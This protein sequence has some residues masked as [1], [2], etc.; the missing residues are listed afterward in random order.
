MS[1]LGTGI[2]QKGIAFMT[3]DRKYHVITSNPGCDVCREGH[4]WT[5]IG[6]MSQVFRAQYSCRDAAELMA[7]ALEEA[8]REGAKSAWLEY[9]E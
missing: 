9:L 6:P 3:S 4:T 2:T 5:V 8:Y 7:D 1:W